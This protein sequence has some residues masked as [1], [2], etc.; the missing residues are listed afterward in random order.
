MGVWLNETTETEGLS[1]I[2][3]RVP[4]FII[5]EVSST[6]GHERA[7]KISV[8]ESFVRRTHIDWLAMQLK[9][10]SRDVGI[11]VTVSAYPSAD[12]V[13]ASPSVQAALQQGHNSVAPA[14]DEPTLSDW[15][16]LLPPV[17]AAPGPGSWTHWMETTLGH[18]HTSCFEQIGLRRVRNLGG[19]CYFDRLWRRLLYFDEEQPIPSNYHPDPE[20]WGQPVGI[21][22]FVH[23]EGKIALN[24]HEISTWMYRTDRPVRNDE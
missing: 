11:A 17:I 2:H 6:E 20:I 22:H 21:C 8:L 18:T 14:A 13:R 24:Q 3:H 23:L 1:L 19:T 5:N 12:Y 16:E 4:C 7:R 15:E 9:A 10:S